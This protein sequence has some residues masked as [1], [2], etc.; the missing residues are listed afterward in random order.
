MPTI[1]TEIRERLMRVAD[2]VTLTGM[3]RSSI[4]RLAAAGRFP[5]PL[6]L[7]ERCSAWR[8][9]QVRLWIAERV[10]GRAA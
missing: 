8:E 2:V 5:K 10:A 4:Y 3:K 9:S 6:K 1:E 7:T